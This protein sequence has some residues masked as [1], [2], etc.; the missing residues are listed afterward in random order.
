MEYLAAIFSSLLPQLPSL[1]LHAVGL[2]FSISR[3]N[4]YPR[5][6]L[7]AGIYFGLALLVRLATQIYII[8]P[9]Y[10]QQQG[11]GMDIDSTFSMLNFICIPI[12]V[13]MDIALLYAIF[14][15]R[16]RSTD[17]NTPIFM[18]DQNG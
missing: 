4:E 5:A 7:A 6:A 3:R 8:L 11:G 2:G 14:A 18:G 12:Y 9:L 13:V 16:N 10:M 15:P 1:I 17:S